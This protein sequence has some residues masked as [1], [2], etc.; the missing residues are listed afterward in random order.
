M[1]TLIVV[2]RQ[3]AYSSRV[4]GVDA[5]VVDVDCDIE[6]WPVGLFSARVT[7]K[8]AGPGGDVL[9]RRCSVSAAPSHF[10]GE[11]LQGPEPEW[12][13]RMSLLHAA[14]AY[15]Q[16]ALWRLAGRG[17]ACLPR[18]LPDTGVTRPQ[19]ACKFEEDG[20][21]WNLVH[22]GALEWPPEPAVG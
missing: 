19:C 16:E 18:A 13:D 5:T 14:D 3:C 22:R 10:S 15:Q 12:F 6:V 11:I 8:A 2:F 20:G 9:S 21:L 1:L 7:L 4:R 17:F